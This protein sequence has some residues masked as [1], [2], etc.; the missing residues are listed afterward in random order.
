M[1]AVPHTRLNQNKRAVFLASNPSLDVHGPV[2]HRFE[3]AASLAHNLTQAKAAGVTLHMQAGGNMVN[4]ARSAQKNGRAPVSLITLRGPTP[5]LPHDVFGEALASDALS[6]VVIPVSGHSHRTLYYEDGSTAYARGSEHLIISPDSH[7]FIA[8]RLQAMLSGA[9]LLGIDNLPNNDVLPLYAVLQRTAKEVDVPIFV[10]AKGL[11][12]QRVLKNIRDGVGAPLIGLKQN[13]EEF[14]SLT[15][16]AAG[17]LGALLA[18]GEL[19]KFAQIILPKARELTET[20]LD[21]DRG[22]FILTTG[23]HPWYAFMGHH[24]FRLTPPKL[25]AISPVGSGD[26]LV[27][28][29]MARLAENGELTASDL[30]QATA[31]SAATATLPGS[32]IATITEATTFFPKVGILELS[33]QSRDRQSEPN[34]FRHV[35]GLF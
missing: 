34:E 21:P 3:A 14:S 31:I 20:Y 32:Q 18:S 27:G 4:A 7:D 28:Y 9:T 19:E 29:L 33:Q 17:E 2:G 26:S 23:P 25:T 24:V 6:P 12:L 8:Q 35:P 30:V 13:L 10:D 5:V 1:Q 11:C 22:I 15:N 16:L